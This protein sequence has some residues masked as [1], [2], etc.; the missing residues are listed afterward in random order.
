MDDP[1][2]I[3]LLNLVALVAI[4]LSMGLQVKVE[5]LLDSVRSARR[6]GLALLANFVLVPAI[7][8]GLLALF[9]PD[10]MVSV[11]FLVLAVCPG[12]PVGPPITGLARGDL[13][14]A[15]GLMAILAALSALLAPLLLGFLIPWVAPTS[16]VAINFLAVVQTLLITQ[17]LPL[18]VGLGLHRAAPR[19]TTVSH[20][21][22]LAAACG[23]PGSSWRTP[24]SSPSTRS[25]PGR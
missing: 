23:D 25:R 4:M 11:G 6:L 13:S 14:A 9:Q 15:V 22:I 20:L 12:A 2:L 3:R 5:V 7:A 21:P 17:L 8:I 1:S 10:P 18:A 16:H 19:L 24:T